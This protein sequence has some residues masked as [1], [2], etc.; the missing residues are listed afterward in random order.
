MYDFDDENEE[1]DAD[2]AMYNDFFGKPKKNSG[3]ASRSDAEVPGQKKRNSSAKPPGKNVHQ[4][5]D[6]SDNSEGREENNDD[7]DDNNSD[8]FEGAD[9]NTRMHGY[10]HIYFVVC[11]L[12]F[13]L[14]MFLDQ[15][16]TVLMMMLE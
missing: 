7:N 4:L 11:Q 10:M 13:I 14:F 8:D 6:D 9:G 1:L 12:I 5:D 15:I 16:I 2:Q 3:R